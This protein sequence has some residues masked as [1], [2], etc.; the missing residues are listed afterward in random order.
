MT[1]GPRKK[2]SFLIF[3]VWLGSSMHNER[4]SI[5]RIERG[6]TT[7][8]GGA[9]H[10]GRPRQSALCLPLG[11]PVSLPMPNVFLMQTG[12]LL[13]NYPNFSMLFISFYKYAF[14]FLIFSQLLSSP[15]CLISPPH[16]FPTHSTS[17]RVAIVVPCDQINLATTIYLFINKRL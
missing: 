7:T 5:Y 3:A 1:G 17:S 2:T 11:T 10:A 6:F 9:S 16:W 8:F 14:Q 13:I 4:E 12:P 15:A